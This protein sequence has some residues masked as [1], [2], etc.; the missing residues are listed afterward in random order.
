LARQREYVDEYRKHRANI[1][2]HIA[3][4]IQKLTETYGEYLPRSFVDELKKVLASGWTETTEFEATV[5]EVLGSLQENL[6]KFIVQRN[7]LRAKISVL[8]S[9]SFSS[10]AALMGFLRSEILPILT[11]VVETL[12]DTMSLLRQ[13]SSQEDPAKVLLREIT[14]AFAFTPHKVN[15]TVVDAFLTFVDKHRGPVKEEILPKEQQSILLE[16]IAPYTFSMADF[17]AMLHAAL[18]TLQE[19]KKRFEDRL[20]LIG[21]ALRGGVDAQE[22]FTEAL[23]ILETTIR[24]LEAYCGKLVDRLREYDTRITSVTLEEASKVVEYLVAKLLKVEH[25]KIL[26]CDRH[27]KPVILTPMQ[28]LILSARAYGVLE[29]RCPHCGHYLLVMEA[30]KAKETFASAAE[31]IR[32]QVLTGERSMGATVLA[33]IWRRLEAEVEAYYNQYR[34]SYYRGSERRTVTPT[35]GRTPI[36]ESDLR[37]TISG[38]RISIVLPHI[39]EFTIGT[40]QT[41]G[42][43]VEEL[44]QKAI[45]ALGKE[46]MKVWQG[47]INVIRRGVKRIVGGVQEE[48]VLEQVQTVGEYLKAEK[49]GER[50]FDIEEARQLGL[51]VQRAQPIQDVRTIQSSV[52]VMRMAVQQAVLRSRSGS[53]W[54]LREARKI[55]REAFE[56]LHQEAKSKLSPRQAAIYLSGVA[57][58]VVG[59]RIEI[60]VQPGLPMIF[61]KGFKGGY[62]WDYILP[63]TKSKGYVDIPLEARSRAEATATIDRLPPTIPIQG[64]PLA[65]GFP[66]GFY[67]SFLARKTLPKYEPRHG[68]NVV[69]R[70]LSEKTA[71]DKFYLKGFVG[72]HG[73]D[74]LQRFLTERIDAVVY[75]AAEWLGEFPIPTTS[76]RIRV[77]MDELKSAILNV[78][79]KLN[80]PDGVLLKDLEQV[81]LAP[82]R[83]EAVVLKRS[84]EEFERTIRKASVENVR[85]I[86]KLSLGQAAELL[87]RG[88]VTFTAT[89]VDAQGGKVANGPYDLHTTITVAPVGKNRYR[90]MVT[91]EL[92]I[93]KKYLESVYQDVAGKVLKDLLDAA[94]AK[95]IAISQQELLTMYKKLQAMRRTDAAQDLEVVS[96]KDH[97]VVQGVVKLRTKLHCQ[98]LPKQRVEVYTLKGE[99]VV[100]DP[101]EFVKILYPMLV[102]RMT[103]AVVSRIVEKEYREV[104]I[105]DLLTALSQVLSPSYLTQLEGILRNYSRYWEAELFISKKRRVTVHSPEDIRRELG[106]IVEKIM[107]AL[108]HKI[109][110]RGLLRDRTVLRLIEELYED[111]K[112]NPVVRAYFPD[113][114]DRLLGIVCRGLGIDLPIIDQTAIR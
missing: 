71:H 27:T 29:L 47:E 74:L 40:T 26:V 113:V 30:A 99:Y 17:K 109:Q 44:R 73:L 110:Q 86:F 25:R 3:N 70:R 51:H 104:E 98:V 15:L 100:V 58:R 103:P 1:R 62:L 16:A 114:P 101:V 21:K 67:G 55:L 91:R 111:L 31:G 28:Y 52:K 57:G 107:R 8:K 77:R 93:N 60:T 6:D 11:P 65:S 80:L 9:Q 19:A 39:P 112:R 38:H 53:L 42:V 69:F 22:A 64:S 63:R 23:E 41:K 92:T 82:E 72:V 43:P 79:T 36:T 32:M 81:L 54:V 108:S 4:T 94:Q 76:A 24:R 96:D 68:V 2:R 88:Q 97:W 75:R 50:L 61:E 7:A 46:F 102:L 105:R 90:V 95:G 18:T 83:A 49:R 34:S 37:K 10:T 85:R 59:N 14:R 13:L 106:G 12:E 5:L 33:E 56:L 78:L 35:T 87:S 20:Q 45:E 84:V 89:G 48:T 66:K